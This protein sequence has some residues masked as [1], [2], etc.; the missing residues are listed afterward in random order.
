MEVQGV[1]GPISLTAMD[2]ALRVAARGPAAR[3]TGL[4]VCLPGTYPSSRE[5]GLGNVAGLLSFV[6]CGTFVRW[7]PRFHKR[8]GRG[9]AAEKSSQQS[10]KQ[11][12]Q[13][14]AAALHAS[15]R[16]GSF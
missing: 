16:Y 12:P 5:A 9:A 3:G 11:K 10:A 13:P 14:R 1:S 4:F 6:P 15:Y 2:C 8:D 7:S